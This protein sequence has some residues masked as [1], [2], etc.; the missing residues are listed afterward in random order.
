MIASVRNAATGDTL[1]NELTT[2]PKGSNSVFVVVTLDLESLS[3]PEKVRDQ[4]KSEVGDR[5]HH[6]DVLISNAAQ[7]TSL[8]QALQTTA[9]ELRSNFETNSIAPLILFQ[10]LWPLMKSRNGEAHVRVPKLL[11][12]SSSVGSIEMQ[13]PLPGGAYGPSKAALNWITKRLHWELENDGLVSVAVHPGYTFS[14]VPQGSL[15]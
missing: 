6:I 1:R 15:S 14:I 11:M 8:G 12:I 10:G 3:N 13:E 4:F 9:E 7:T 5:I 2:T